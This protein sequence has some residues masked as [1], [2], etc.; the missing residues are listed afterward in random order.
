MKTSTRSQTQT[1]S[2]IQTLHKITLL[3]KDLLNN[4]DENTNTSKLNINFNK[5]M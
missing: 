4:W 1:N 2:E 5:Y 3:L